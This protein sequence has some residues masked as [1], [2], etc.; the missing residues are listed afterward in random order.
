MI[1]FSQNS[2][3]IDD[4]L[5]LPVS[6]IEARLLEQARAILPNGSHHIWGEALHQGNQ[7]W[8]GLHPETILTPYQELKEIC[9][10]LSP[11]PEELIVD[12]G[13]GYGRLGLTLASL[14]P[15]THFLGI[16][17]VPERVEAG[18]EILNSLGRSNLNLIT[19]DLTAEEFRVPEAEYYFIYDFGKIPHIRSILKQLSDLADKRRFKLV[20]RGG[21]IRSLIDNEFPWLIE[22][23]RREKYSI[24]EA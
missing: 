1:N 18:K 22:I 20:A 16:E 23:H 9:E 5:G 24:Y 3:A 7:T 11:C 21:G 4:Y 6:E 10:L 8:V 17:Y 14:F 15:E 13:A 19:G 12:L 2:S